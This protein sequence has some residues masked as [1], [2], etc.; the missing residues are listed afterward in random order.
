MGKSLIL[1]NI[2]SVSLLIF[3][4]LYLVFTLSYI[5]TIKEMSIYIFKPYLILSDWVCSRGNVAFPLT[6]YVSLFLPPFL[7]NSFS[8]YIT[9]NTYLRQGCIIVTYQLWLERSGKRWCPRDCGPHT[10]TRPS[11]RLV[12]I[13]VQQMVKKLGCRCRRRA[14]GLWLP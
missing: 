8:L 10:C 4:H 9:H 1:F 11:A 13:G 12:S 5:L 14:S 2:I 7:S 3:T 6:L